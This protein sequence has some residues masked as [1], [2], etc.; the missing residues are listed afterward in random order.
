MVSDQRRQ[1]DGLEFAPAGAPDTIYNLWKGFSV[2]PKPGDCSL[3]L[4]HIRSNICNGDDELY[5]WVS[6][7]CAQIVQQPDQKMGTS[8]VLIG[9]EGTGKTV[10]GT[11]I[12]SLFQDHYV[13][14]SDPRYITRGFNSHM[15]QCLLLHAE[16]AFWAGDKTA[17]GRLKDLI[18]GETHLVEFKGIEPFPV[19]NYIRLLVT[20]NNDWAVPAGLGARRF[21]VLKVSDTH[22]M[23]IPYF[24]AIMEQIENGGREALLHYLL[25]YDLSSVDLRI[26]PRTEPYWS[27]RY[28]A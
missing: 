7:W 11:V 26:V 2:K 15:V 12:G 25:N 23:D 21:A 4:E 13:A 24:A 5:N 27:S 17:E 8:L 9:G 1:Y 18:T 6:G 28:T 3:F 14:V 22:Q 10:F 16:E 19:R 20:T